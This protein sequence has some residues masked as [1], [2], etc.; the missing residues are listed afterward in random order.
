M[1]LIEQPLAEL[2]ILVGDLG[3]V[4][5]RAPWRQ[6]A[7]GVSC[8]ANIESPAEIPLRSQ[9]SQYI[10]A[11]ATIARRAL[12][13]SSPTKRG[14]ATRESRPWPP[15]SEPLRSVPDQSSPGQTR[16]FVDHP[17]HYLTRSAVCASEAIQSTPP[18]GTPPRPNAA[19]IY[20]TSRAANASS[21]TTS[22]TPYQP[23]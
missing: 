14:T 17:R 11:A 8:S 3:E 16:S 5:L 20:T 23:E 22:T 9:L 10:S 19:T 1:P 15:T 6:P 21:T 7:G 13:D 18:R 2:L 12:K 4:T